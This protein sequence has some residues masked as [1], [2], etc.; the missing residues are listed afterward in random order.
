M[1]TTDDLRFF[2]FLSNA[3]SLAQAARAL[4]VTPPA[5]TQRL[6]SLEKRLGVRLVNRSGRG[7]AL[8]DEGRLLAAR[9]EQ[10]C[11]ELSDLADELSG[12]RGVVA[13]HLRIVA[14]L[15]FGQRYVAPL[16]ATFREESENITASLVLSDGP[17]RLS[18]D[19]WDVMIH[20][21]ELR[22]SSLVGYPLAPNRRVL[23]ASPAYLSRRG[24]P[25]NPEDLRNHDCIA[26]REN[27]ED[28]TLWRF[29]RADGP[30]LP[31]RVAPVLSCNAGGTALDWA[32][33]GHGIVVRSEW[34]VAPHLKTRSLVPLLTEWQ[35]PD[36]D[37]VA[38]VKSRQ[39]R[40][41]RTA[42]FL[43]VL[44]SAFETPPW[45]TPE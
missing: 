15:G 11:G 10:I 33:A 9:A 3:T 24:A 25:A 21:G 13:G 43:N 34:D 20:I 36:A 28:V 16:I 4:D 35:L 7:I 37:V 14:P 2:L 12:R 1:I 32:L 44:R 5:V 42:G 29:K 19:S 18:S 27:D 6:Q 38:L 22:D 40:S 30:A 8:T 23:C 45:R 41:A 26:L 39:E 31:I 17:P